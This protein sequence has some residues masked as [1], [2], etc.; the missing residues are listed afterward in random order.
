[1]VTP[2]AGGISET[3]TDLNT[4]DADLSTI[5]QG[6]GVLNSKLDSAVQCL[7]YPSELAGDL[8]ELYSGIT[9]VKEAL[10][11]VALIPDVGELVPEVKDAMTVLQTAVNTGRKPVNDFAAD[12]SPYKDAAEKL[13]SKVNSAMNFVDSSDT[14][15]QTFS[16]ALQNVEKCVNSLPDGTAKTDAI[17]YLNTFGNTL[18]PEVS[19]LNSV[20]GS[21]I[22][23]GNEIVTAVD[24]FEG[25]MKNDVV[26]VRK[27]LASFLSDFNPLFSALKS[28]DNI[29]EQKITVP[30]GLKI[31][32]P[33]YDPF[34]WHVKVEYFTFTVEEIINGI[35]DILEEVETLLIDAVKSLVGPLVTTVMDEFNKIK[36][37]LIAGIPG[38]SSL[39]TAFDSI[40]SDVDAVTTNFSSVFKGL[41]T[42][43]ADLQNYET[44]LTANLTTL[45]KYLEGS[46]CV[47]LL[48]SL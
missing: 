8:N 15:V 29:L 1:M 19:A 40:Q 2:T 6:I 7:S 24:N 17:G 3:I 12:V 25:T 35:D 42:L 22:S 47:K 39:S 26:S 16:T 9:T 28:V 31:Q 18:N 10:T 11:L 38:L 20:L 4:T 33:W 41:S 13:Q 23:N 43:S 36:A 14:D 44:Q 5:S 37:T 21:V 27:D 34:D 46:P 32:G 45:R 30:Y 48:E